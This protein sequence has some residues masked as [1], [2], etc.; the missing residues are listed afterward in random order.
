MAFFVYPMCPIAVASHAC[1]VLAMA[2]TVV[3]QV[4]PTKTSVCSR[5]HL[6]LDLQS[7]GSD[8]NDQ[9]V[10]HVMHVV[11]FHTNQFIQDRDEA[12]RRELWAPAHLAAYYR[13]LTVEAPASEKA[14]GHLE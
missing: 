8:N 13:D 4:L 1:R 3:N 12:L 14:F 2:C 5:R 7:P 10:N 9:L 11:Y 6:V